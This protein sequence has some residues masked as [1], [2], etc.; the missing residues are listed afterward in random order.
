MKPLTPSKIGV[1][2]LLVQLLVPQG[3]QHLHADIQ[4]RTIISLIGFLCV[5]SYTSDIGFRIVFAPIS[6]LG[7]SFLFFGLGFIFIYQVV[8][9]CKGKAGRTSTIV[10]GFASICPI[11]FLMTIPDLLFGFIGTQLPLPIL[12]VTGL[13][14]MRNAGP[15]KPTTPWDEKS[16]LQIDSS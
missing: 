10:A 11:L 6:G 15:K 1:I 4:D 2:L 3:L 8:Q 7:Y 14:A 16:N 9:Y 13:A 12:L 5:F